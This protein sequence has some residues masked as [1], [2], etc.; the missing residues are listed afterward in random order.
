MIYRFQYTAFLKPGIDEGDML[1]KAKIDAQ[2]SVAEKLCL[3]LSLFRYENEL[4]LYFESTYDSLTPDRILPSMKDYLENDWTF[5][6]NVYYTSVAS[7]EGWWARQGNKKPVGRLGRLVPEKK[8]S[9]VYYHREIMKE[10]LFEGDKY[11]FIGLLENTLFLYSESPEIRTHIRSEL[12]GESKIIEEWRSVNP[13]SHFDH[14]FSGEPNFVYME[15]IL[16]C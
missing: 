7:D 13:R 9:Y 4:Y 12:T 16:C 2:K 14:D 6:D 5:M 1:K 3:T 15:E 8:N 10:G 11:L